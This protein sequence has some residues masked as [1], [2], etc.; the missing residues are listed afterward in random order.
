MRVDD[1]M[2][3]KTGWTLGRSV[4]RMIKGHGDSLRGDD[5][6]YDRHVRS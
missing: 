3:D 4:N 1:G 5:A 2:P 6:R